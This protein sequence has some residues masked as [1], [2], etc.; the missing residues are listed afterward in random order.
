MKDPR[1]RSELLIAQVN[2]L[3]QQ[4]TKLMPTERNYLAHALVVNWAQDVAGH[5]G[6]LTPAVVIFLLPQPKVSFGR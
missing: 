4:M 6:R 5:P 3:V 1:A 2:T